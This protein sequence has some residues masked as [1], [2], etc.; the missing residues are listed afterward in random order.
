MTFKEDNMT[1]M[2]AKENIEDYQTD[3][4]LAIEIR[5]GKENMKKGSEDSVTLSKVN[6]KRYSQ[7]TQGQLL[8]KIE[9]GNYETFGVYI[10]D[11]AK[12]YYETS[13][14]IPLI[15]KQE[16]YLVELLE[17]IYGIVKK[18]SKELT[19]HIKLTNWDSI[20][21]KLGLA[22]C[23]LSAPGKVEIEVLSHG[24]GEVEKYLNKE[25]LVEC[26]KED[27]LPL[28]I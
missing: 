4:V 20:S 8:T 9:E 15:T 3:I 21:N 12:E 1:I 14:G 27:A 24:D 26:M 23:L 17:S 19:A 13:V 11:D 2:V 5:N 16:T 6:T 10:Q 18:G 28:A 7:Y 22:I 25:K